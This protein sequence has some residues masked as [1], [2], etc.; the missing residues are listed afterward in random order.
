MIGE[1]RG[2]ENFI[3]SLAVL[4]SGE[5]VSAGEDRTVR[6][7]DK[8]QCI[9]V[10]T[11]PAISVWSVAVCKENGDIVTGA[12]DKIVRVFTRSQERY[13][14]AQTSAAFEESV[15]AS[16]IPQQ[17]LGDINKTDL[18]G[19]EFL[20]QRS[21]VKEGQVQMVKETNGNVS[22]YQW[23]SGANQWVM[24][25]TVVDASGGG[26][27]TSYN[28]KEYDY[29]FDVDI[30]D[31]KPALKLPYNATQNPYEAAQKFIDD[32]ELPQAYLDQVATFITTNSKGAT[33]QQQSGPAQ[34]ALPGSDPW[35]TDSRYRPG[36]ASTAAPS[37][38]A[39]RPKT[40]PQKQ[41]LNIA[42][43]N[44]QTIRKKAVEFNQALETEGRKDI[45]FSSANL[46]SFAQTVQQ[47]DPISKNPGTSLPLD[48][49]GIGM[50]VHMATDWPADKRLPGL[51]LLRL[52]A[53]S[54][55]TAQYTNAGDETIVSIIASSGN[56]SADAP[57]N[58][59]MMA[60]R[61]L[62]NL[63]SH[64]AGR[65]L[66]DAE[67]DKVHA[68][69]SPFISNTNRNMMIAITTL[70]I[71]YAVLLR[72]AAPDHDSDRAI[73]LLDE[74]TK[75]MTSATDAEALY[76][77]LV[78]AGTLLALGK[79]FKDLAREALGFDRAVARVQGEKAGSEPRIKAVIKEML[80]EIK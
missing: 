47:L 11:H 77:A 59:T 61:A 3:Y 39:A 8:G 6:I 20:T 35:G 12:S 15:K 64:Q 62:A 16:A 37:Q 63:F 74:L 78:G 4:P 17:S 70:Y 54:E 13:A 30:E 68:L 14:A 21:G 45:T 51:D 7:W 69:V 42:T 25:G 60:I 71:N 44:L 2:H 26:S 58:N 73:T 27:K 49:E 22:A 23:S 72:V 65:L 38:P 76:R 79:D 55:H 32:N 18:P 40:L 52:A 48:N 19:P 28:G 56:I 75:I 41:Y 50:I 29:V 43:A 33:L 5:I 31:G 67:F 46:E 10:I 80:D 24:V 34:P 1:L 66:M 9:Q 53:V 57:M 36:D